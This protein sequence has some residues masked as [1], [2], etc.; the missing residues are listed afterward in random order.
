MLYELEA[1]NQQQILS[2]FVTHLDHINDFVDSSSDEADWLEKL[3]VLH[4]KA[5]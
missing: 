5:L 4:I 3:S 2:I 1:T